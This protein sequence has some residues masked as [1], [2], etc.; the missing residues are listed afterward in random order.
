[1][2]A[3]PSG[4]QRAPAASPDTS[5]PIDMSDGTTHP[6]LLRRWDC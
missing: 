4:L 1:V 5:L 6:V 3:A 2:P